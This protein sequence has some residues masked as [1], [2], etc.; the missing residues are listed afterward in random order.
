MSVI[1]TAG[2]GA[3]QAAKQATTTIP[4][5]QAQGGDLVLAGLVAS[6]ARPGG[7]ITGL[8]IQDVEGG[9][10]RLELLKD[11]VPHAENA[12]KLDAKTYGKN[13]GTLLALSHWTLQ[14]PE[15]PW[16]HLEILRRALPRAM[17]GER[18]R[19][20]EHGQHADKTPDA[21]D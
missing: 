5:V 17:G 16:P 1:V 7:N 10:K 12:R 13:A 21:F 2:L 3:T 9:G 6:L 18:D 14:N 4:I 15:A 20:G 11:A 8:S 19:H